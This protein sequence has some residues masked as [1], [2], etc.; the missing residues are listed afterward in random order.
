MRNLISKVKGWFE[1]SEKKKDYLI[2]G[3]A[4]HL[5]ESNQAFFDEMRGS[6]SNRSEKEVTVLVDMLNRM[7][8]VRPPSKSERAKIM[9]LDPSEIA[10]HAKQ[11]L[12]E[13]FLSLSLSGVSEEAMAEIIRIVKLDIE[14]QSA[15]NLRKYPNV[16]IMGQLETDMKQR[17]N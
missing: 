11:N 9:E 10:E 4:P 17:A 15:Q 14:H 13:Q 1:P 5:R 12:K 7:N 3:L 6:K 2:E 8:D 16:S